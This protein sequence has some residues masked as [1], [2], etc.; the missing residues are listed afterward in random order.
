MRRA[1]RALPLPRAPAALAILVSLAIS[2]VL[3][4]LAVPGLLEAASDA[5]GRTGSSPGGEPTD[6]ETALREGNRRFRAGRLEEALDAYAAGWS[7][8]SPDPV[9]AYNLGTTA[10]HLGRLPEAVLWYRRALW[11][12]P[13]EDR[14]LRENLSQARR[15]LGT[16]PPQPAGLLAGLAAHRALAWALAALLAWGWLALLLMRRRGLSAGPVW[17]PGVLAGT[18]LALAVAGLAAPRLAPRPAVLLK[19][20]GEGDAALPAGS[21]VWVTSAAAGADEVRQDGLQLL[22]PAA[23]VAMVEP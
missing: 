17:T 23:T 14:W 9:L 3:A 4:V 5:P 2:A 20:C 8:E 21:E 1:G 15:R 19:S 7:P 6:P 18:A 13:T 16:R 22:C 10:H 11:A 12:S